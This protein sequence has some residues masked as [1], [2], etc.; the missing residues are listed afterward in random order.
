MHEE[1]DD[2]ILA[3]SAPVVNYGGAGCSDVR[4]GWFTTR[5]LEP[6][7]ERNFVRDINFRWYRWFRGMVLVLVVYNLFMATFYFAV[8]A[9]TSSHLPQNAPI[10]RS[11]FF[12]DEV[13]LGSKFLA[14]SV[15]ITPC[16][17]SLT[18]YALMHTRVFNLHT[19]QTFIMVATLG[20]FVAYDWPCHV[21]QI[22][23]LA[24][25][26]ERSPSAEANYTSGDDGVL[27][28][29]IFVR[30]CAHVGTSLFADIVTVALMPQ[31][32]PTMA[33]LF[34]LHLSF[35]VRSNYLWMF[36]YQ[37]SLF[38]VLIVYHVA[39]LCLAYAASY[40]KNTSLRQQWLIRRELQ[41]TKDERIEQLGREKER[42]DYERAFALKSRAGRGDRE[43]NA[44]DPGVS[45]LFGPDGAD[46][47]R[48]ALGA[49]GAGGSDGHGAA[50]RGGG[51]MSACTSSVAADD[52][53]L[54]WG[55]TTVAFSAD[56]NLAASAGGRMSLRPPS[57]STAGRGDAIS[58]AGS[59]TECSELLAM[60]AGLSGR[61]GIVPEDTIGFARECGASTEL[62]L[63]EWV[64]HVQRGQSDDGYGEGSAAEPTRPAE[65]AHHA[66]RDA[67]RRASATGL[68]SKT[69]SGSMGSGSASGS[70]EGN[71][72]IRG[73]DGT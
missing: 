60:T 65:A 29:R 46:G 48:R 73:A 25:T 64:A 49:A 56:E 12:G 18:L 61:D 3:A 26:M 14:N 71:G 28:R 39:S 36:H 37:T 10:G 11:A 72:V 57:R 15:M 43:T 21:S 1:Q 67:A 33:T 32:I 55:P 58:S 19:Y 51:G 44:G 59:M 69:P 16:L 9:P 45:P 13:A 17:Q 30:T 27:V 38:D 23:G 68:S 52:V 34:F 50:E 47:A 31:H 62:E 24:S 54:E 20:T 5:I 35:L 63:A 66:A 8:I 2:N 42:L 70:T 40:L 22:M 41:R 7:F 6:A 53:D 4:L